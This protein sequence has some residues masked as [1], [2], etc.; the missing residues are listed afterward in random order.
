HNVFVT[1]D[2]QI[3]LLGF[4]GAHEMAE[5]WPRH[6][7]H[8][9]PLGYL[10]P[11]QVRE[12]AVDGRAD[13]FAVGV[14]LWELVTGRRLWQ[15]QADASIVRRLGDGDIPSLPDDPSLPPGLVEVCAR[16]LAP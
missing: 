10:A 5:V 16:A 12:H 6:R 7:R 15:S 14:M 4:G 9:G 11:E 1:Y 3:K 8:R 2:G 13:V